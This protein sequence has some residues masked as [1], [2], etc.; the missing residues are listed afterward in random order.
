MYCGR[1]FS[2]LEPSESKVVGL[3]FVNDMNENETL[4]SSSWDVWVVAGVDLRNTTILQGPSVEVV[5]KDGSLKTGTIQ[6]IGNPLPGVTYRLRANVV[7][8]RGNVLNL[9]SHV[10]GITSRT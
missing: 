10:R 6:R 9:W 1:E 8:A 2:P 4:L 5:P 3:D 7:T